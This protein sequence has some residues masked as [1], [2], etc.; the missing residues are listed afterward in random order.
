[1]TT[2]L[3][4]LLYLVVAADACL[5]RQTKIGTNDVGSW[6]KSSI[7]G[8]LSPF[9]MIGRIYTFAFPE[10]LTTEV[11]DALAARKQAADALAQESDALG[12]QRPP[13][14]VLPGAEGSPSAAPG[15]RHA[16]VT[17]SAG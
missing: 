7:F 4:I 8:L 11:D 1:M 5:N 15:E 2:F 12:E 10:S 14:D 3:F 16:G 13:I 17:S 6:I 9:R